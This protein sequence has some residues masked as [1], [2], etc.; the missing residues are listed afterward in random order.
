MPNLSQILK[1]EIARISRREV[2]ASVG[3]LRNSNYNL[4]R[5]VAALKRKTAQLE[6][7]NKRLSVFIHKSAQDQASNLSPDIAQK[8]RITGRTVK[9]LRSKLGLSQVS[10]ARL[11]GVS[12]LTVGLMERKKGRLRPRS[13][14]LANLIML[15]GLGKREVRRRL[16]EMGEKQA[17]VVRK[18]GNRSGISKEQLIELQKTLKT[19][20]AIGAKFGISRQ[21]VHQLRVKYNIES[22][23]D[24][25][26][27]RDKRIA[28]IYKTGKSGAAIAKEMGLSISQLYRIIKRVSKK[29]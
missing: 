4:K 26:E 11:L 3:P 8:V 20:A 5:A 1:A 29:S 6:T 17:P 19:D 23:R 28:E 25:N 10:F 9:A 14:T 27:G 15:R 18:R 22:V 13:A 24:K 2:K 7:E 21:A 16:E 12:N